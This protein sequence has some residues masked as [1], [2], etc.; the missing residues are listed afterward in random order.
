MPVNPQYL[1]LIEK[2]KDIRRKI[3]FFILVWGSGG[4]DVLAN[5]KRKNMVNVLATEFGEKNVLMSEDPALENLKNRYGDIVAESIQLDAADFVIILDT[6]LGPHLEAQQYHYKLTNK[7]IVLCNDKYK[8]VKS[9]PSN[10]R[11]K[12]DLVWFK[13]DEYKNCNLICNPT[14]DDLYEHCLKKACLLREMKYDK[15]KGLI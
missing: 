5:K 11:Y 8:N 10:L 13:E 7:S 2:Q 15:K 4:S 12:Y 6:S 14:G 9:Y 3:D 1:K